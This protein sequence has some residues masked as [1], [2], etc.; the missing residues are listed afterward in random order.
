MA[1][2]PTDVDVDDIETW[3]DE[4]LDITKSAGVADEAD[5]KRLVK[6]LEKRFARASREDEQRLA[7]WTDL[8][9]QIHVNHVSVFVCACMHP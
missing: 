5:R 7:H 3:R 4:W 8:Q 9:R 1:E 2:L 6:W